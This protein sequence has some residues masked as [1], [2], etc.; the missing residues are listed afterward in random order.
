MDPLVMRPYPLHKS[1]RICVSTNAVR[2]DVQQIQR[3]ISRQSDATHLLSTLDDWLRT[4]PLGCN[5][6][7]VKGIDWGSLFRH[8]DVKWVL[9]AEENTR[10]SRTRQSF[11]KHLSLLGLND[12]CKMRMSRAQFGWLQSFKHQLHVRY[13]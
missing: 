2:D 9:K 4:V 13:T 10:M 1:N 11:A 3:I 8:A 6:R 5:Y 12:D 7:V